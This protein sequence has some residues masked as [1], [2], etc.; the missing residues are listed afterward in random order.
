MCLPCTLV[1]DCYCA[2]LPTTNPSQHSQAVYV[3]LD[4]VARFLGQ[5][6]PTAEG[7][8]TQAQS[9]AQAVG[10]QA[11]PATQAQASS[12]TE[13]ITSS[14]APAAEAIKSQADSASEAV[15]SQ[16]AP[17]AEAIKSQADSASE[18]LKSQAQDV[19]PSQAETVTQGLQT[20]ATWDSVTE[21]IKAAGEQ[22]QEQ[23]KS[24]SDLLPSTS[25]SPPTPAAICICMSGFCV[26][27][28]M[29]IICLHSASAG[30][31]LLKD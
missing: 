8:S 3:M 7:V 28:V 1:C 20:P 26:T 29:T 15:K 10:S 2:Q 21:S 4:S 13:A 25:V 16:V 31:K 18:A 19:V 23:L 14:A 27:G 17:V 11:E 24:S 5:V 22:V 30:R 6:G 9:R 12:A